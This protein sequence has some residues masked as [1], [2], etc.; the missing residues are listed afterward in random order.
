MDQFV[1]LYHKMPNDSPRDDHWDLM[2]QHRDVLLT[3]A[4]EKPPAKGQV[5]TG[6]KLNDHDPKYL[7]YEGPISGDRGQVTRIISG[8]FKWLTSESAELRFQGKTLKMTTT[9]L[10]NNM[11]RFEFT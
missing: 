4:L 11:F 9:P 3:W 2:L 1:V 10:P 6:Q 7:H 8:T 5:C